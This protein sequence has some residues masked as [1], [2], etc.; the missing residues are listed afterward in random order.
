MTVQQFMRLPEG[1]RRSVI[2]PSLLTQSQYDTAISVA[3][4][5]PALVVAKAFFKVTGE[6]VVT[7]SSLVQLVVKA[8]VI[9]PGYPS[10]SIPEVNELDLEDIDPDEDDLDALLGRK[11]AKSTRAKNP[12]GSTQ[13]PTPDSKPVQP[14]L[15]HAPYFARDH[16]PRWNVFLA[17][18]KPG[19]MAVPPF[20]FTTFQ[21]P[22]F[23]DSGEPTFNIQTLKMQFQAPQQVGNFTFV[24]HLI[25]D[26]YIGFDSKQEVTLVVE[27]LDKAMKMNE[28]DEI[29]EPDEGMLPVASSY[30]VNPLA[31]ASTD[32]IAGQMAALK[33]GGLS[34]PPK[35][36][37]KKLGKKVE[38]EGGDSSEEES[39]TDGD[40]TDTS[41][42]DTETEDEGE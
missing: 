30:F 32:S 39:D 42:T 37:V 9:P 29:S 11:P 24:M 18:S 21:K 13:P 26:S 15:A 6:R 19:K 1:K 4:Q 10:T 16:S 28:E 31:N 2:A 12:D 3:K 34:A 40:V 7:P 38:E 22:M 36:K 14:P 27:D 8:R 5:I 25:C 23:T 17:D 41:E 20:T 33:T 35:K